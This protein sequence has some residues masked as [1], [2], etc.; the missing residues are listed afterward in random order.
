MRRAQ[1]ASPSIDVEVSIHGSVRYMPWT[2]QHHQRGRLLQ[3][4][5]GSLQFIETL[6][7]VT[8]IC[9]GRFMSRFGSA[10]RSSSPDEKLTICIPAQLTALL[11]VLILPLVSSRDTRGTYGAQHTDE[12]SNDCTGKR[13]DPF[14]HGHH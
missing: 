12:A 2:L 8:G 5:A 10:E 4:F 3:L 1:S 9:S 11:F 6:R 13:V 7:D 14:A